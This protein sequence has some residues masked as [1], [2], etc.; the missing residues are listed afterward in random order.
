[1]KQLVIYSALW[2]SPCNAM[3]SQMKDLE[4]PVDMVSFVDVDKQKEQTKS[5]SVRSVPTLILFED[6]VEIRRTTGF[7]GPNKLV[8]FCTT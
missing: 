7:Q 1:M 8:E 6:G 2:C 5:F 4:L 3:K